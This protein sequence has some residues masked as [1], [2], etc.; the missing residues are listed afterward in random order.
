MDKKTKRNAN[1]KTAIVAYS[2]W[3]KA[4]DINKYDHYRIQ[5]HLVIER[6]RT[7]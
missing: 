3:Y 6:S 5:K 2:G 7:F 4:A 1:L